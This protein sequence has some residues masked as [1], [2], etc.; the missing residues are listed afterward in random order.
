VVRVELFVSFFLHG[1]LDGSVCSASV[2][3][4]PG[5]EKVMSCCLEIVALLERN[6]GVSGLHL[7]FLSPGF[8]RNVFFRLAPRILCSLESFGWLALLVNLSPPLFGEINCAEHGILLN[9]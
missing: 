1:L 3:L 6:D 2:D 4:D 7:Q 8:L 5:G 9:P